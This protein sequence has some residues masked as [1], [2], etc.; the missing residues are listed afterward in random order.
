VPGYPAP[1]T[2]PRRRFVPIERS[3]A[4][5][6]GRPGE[7]APTDPDN[8]RGALR[9]IAEALLDHGIEDARLVAGVAHLQDHER[10]L[11][12]LEA[13]QDA[14][15]HEATAVRETVADREASLRFALGELELAYGDAEK[16]Q[17][18]EARLAAATADG[19]RV[20][21]LELG[22]AEI[23]GL[24][25]QALDRVKAAYDALER[26]VD[27]QLAANAARAGF[28]AISERFATVRARRQPR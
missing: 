5:L 7:R 20:R 28:A 1:R 12:R 11:A 26:I 15:E 13:A 18:L 6:E 19:D 27:E 17:E 22:L 14:L 10:A 24:R 4:S 3:P 25:A 9:E 2:E 16:R 23:A 21:A 8:V